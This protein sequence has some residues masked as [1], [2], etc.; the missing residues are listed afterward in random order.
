VNQPEW[1]E[2]GKGAVGTEGIVLEAF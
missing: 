2:P 1:L